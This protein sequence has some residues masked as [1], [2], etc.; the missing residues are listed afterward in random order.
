MIL[1]PLCFSHDGAELGDGPGS[2]VGSTSTVGSSP[3]RSVGPQDTVNI[4]RI[5]RTTTERFLF[6]VLVF[7]VLIPERT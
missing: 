7:L 4:V 2:G 3:M 1:Q 5:S 6:I